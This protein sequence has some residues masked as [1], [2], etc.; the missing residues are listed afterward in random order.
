MR[1]LSVTESVPEDVIVLVR[2][3]RRVVVLSGAGMS[4]ESGVPTFREVQT[5][6]REQFSAEELATTD[7]FEADPALVW[8]W[9]RWRQSLID[10]FSPNPAHRAVARWQRHLSGHQ[11]WL[12]VVTQNVD[13]LHERAGAEV[14]GHLHGSI[15]G[16]RCADCGFPARLSAPGY[17]GFTA[18]P[19][20]EEPPSC[21]H[22]P[23]GLLRPDV[24]WFGEML[25]A[26][27]FDA[28][29]AAI[30]AADLVMVVGTSGIV[31]PA[32]SLPLLGLERGIPLI[33]I[34]PEETGITDVMD[35]AIRGR[36]AQ[37]LPVLLEAAGIG[38]DG[39]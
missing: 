11:E 29:A 10:A 39:G 31:Q 30:R 1:E 27:P 34:N 16:H 37:V 28:A 36:S 12:A 17:D 24:V 26:A 19:E 5:G 33:E 25:P 35:F 6:L 22:C 21:E 32:A 20:P 4:A 14:L 8:T 18:P 13:D 38:E 7:A 15:A 23:Q 9:Y 3:S 2:E